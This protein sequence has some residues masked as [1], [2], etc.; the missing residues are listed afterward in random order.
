MSVSPIGYT[1]NMYNLCEMRNCLNDMCVLCLCKPNR[2]FRRAFSAISLSLLV[3]LCPI[4]YVH[5]TDSQD[6]AADI[7]HKAHSI[8]LLHRISF[9]FIAKICT[10]SSSSFLFCVAAFFFFFCQRKILLKR[11]SVCSKQNY[12]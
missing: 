1:L 10:F 9:F 4:K 12:M 5:L 3:E 6:M 11:Q 2:T 7:L 8:I